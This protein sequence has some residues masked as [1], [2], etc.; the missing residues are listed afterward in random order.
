MSTGL[1]LVMF[2]SF[3]DFQAIVEKGGRFL[4]APVSGSKKPAEDGTLIILAAG[5]EVML[6]GC[7]TFVKS[8]IC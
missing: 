4:E 2:L 1:N 8:C 5:D 3:S 7:F 6:K